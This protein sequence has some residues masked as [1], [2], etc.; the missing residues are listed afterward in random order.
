MNKF[1][2]L[3]AAIVKVVEVKTDDVPVKTAVHNRKYEKIL[4]GRRRIQAGEWKP[5]SVLVGR[6]K[7]TKV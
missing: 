5:N 7:F 3:A 4:E 1:H 2:Q 6:F